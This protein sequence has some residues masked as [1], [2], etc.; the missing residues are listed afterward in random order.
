MGF[1]GFLCEG[2]I[3][4]KCVEFQ[5]KRLKILFFGGNFL[6]LFNPGFYF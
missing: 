3:L 2:F 1:C 4:N 5:I 6:K